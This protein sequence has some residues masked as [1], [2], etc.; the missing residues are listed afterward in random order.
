M[1]YTIIRAVVLT[2]LATVAATSCGTLDSVEKT[3][4]A[5]DEV[6]STIRNEVNTLVESGLAAT[7]REARCYRTRKIL[8]YKRHSTTAYLL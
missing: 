2:F 7:G 5:L 6:Q 4:E 8:G 3:D 1:R